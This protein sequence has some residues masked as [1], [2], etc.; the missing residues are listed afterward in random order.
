MP[1][2]NLE[3]LRMA[4]ERL[5][6]LL[7]EIVFVG[8][9]VTGLLIDD[10]GAAPVRT[11][12][13][14]RCDWRDRLLCGVRDLLGTASRRIFSGQNWRLFGVAEKATTSQVTTLRTS[15]QLWADALH[16][17]KR[18]KRRLGICAATWFPPRGLFW[19]TNDFSIHCQ[20][21]SCQIW[22]VRRGLVNL[23]ASSVS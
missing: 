4:A 14:R 19:K 6:P 10:P 16:F 23:F 22:P 17:S 5:R 21:F 20:D 15:S 1:N 18:W 11:T 2:P 7:P 13:G 3:L 9:C 12:Y 8:G